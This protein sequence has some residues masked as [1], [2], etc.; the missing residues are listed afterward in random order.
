MCVYLFGCSRAHI[1]LKL[2]APN[3]S[4]WTLA[5]SHPGPRLQNIDSQL[6]ASC[7]GD[8][9][10]WGR[11]GRGHAEVTPLI[12]VFYVLFFFWLFLC[13]SFLVCQGKAL[14]HEIHNAHTNKHA[15]GPWS[16][17]NTARTCCHSPPAFGYTLLYTHTH[18]LPLPVH[19]HTHTNTRSMWTT[20]P[21]HD[22]V[23][24]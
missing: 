21:G 14:P 6:R 9:G 15:S 11:R 17:L 5:R 16:C 2:S 22:K 12:F 8:G 7:R 1:R 18:G 20:H 24:R 13:L 3:L 4:L 10:G 23:L 19:N